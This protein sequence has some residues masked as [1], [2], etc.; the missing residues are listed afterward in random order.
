MSDPHKPA[1][2]IPV[3]FSD[4]LDQR[5][6]DRAPH[7]DADARTRRVHFSAAGARS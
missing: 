1:A 7:N 2:V 5:A 4:P 3:T 6:T